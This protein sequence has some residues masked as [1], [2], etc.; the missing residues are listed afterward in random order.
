MT[1]KLGRAFAISQAGKYDYRI[2]Q[3]AGHR[4]PGRFGVWPNPLKEEL[5]HLGLWGKHS[6]SKFIPEQYKTANRAARLALLQGLL[7][8]DG[9][10]EKTGSV[11]FATSSEQL[12]DEVIELAR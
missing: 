1:A 5:K 9:W 6:E 11:R 10:V 2:V 8:A 12:A 7:D 4:R 3:S